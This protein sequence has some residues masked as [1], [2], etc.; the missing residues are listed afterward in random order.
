M[1]KEKSDAALAKIFDDPSFPLYFIDGP[2]GSWAG[3]AWVEHS[4]RLFRHEAPANVRVFLHEFIYTIPQGAPKK[5]DK[6]L[7]A[8]R[9]VVR[10]RY[11]VETCLFD[12]D[13]F[14]VAVK[15]EIMRVGPERVCRQLFHHVAFSFDPS[16]HD[17]WL[18]WLY[19]RTILSTPRTLHPS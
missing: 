11:Q 15:Q 14:Y 18:Q 13:Y 2:R 8:G 4:S 19:L 3:A 12:V 1:G 6:Y 5:N 7:F 17:N 10:N 9:R 16:F